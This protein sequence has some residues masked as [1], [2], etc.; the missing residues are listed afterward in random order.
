MAQS[1]GTGASWIHSGAPPTH[2]TDAHVHTEHAQVTC[3]NQ[4]RG[5]CQCLGFGKGCVALP[6]RFL[7][8]PV[9]IYFKIKVN[10]K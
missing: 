4:P 7:G 9:N 8:A 2:L 10:S 1:W 3:L 6:V 5:L